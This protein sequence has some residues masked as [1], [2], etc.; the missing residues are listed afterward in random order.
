[1]KEPPCWRI[2]L[3]GGHSGEFCDHAEGTLREM[4]E[5]AVAAGY[6]TFGVSE[7]APRPEAFLYE[8]ERALGWDAEKL[9]ADFHRYTHTINTLA[10]AFAPQLM[11]LRGFEAEV[12]PQQTYV[13][14]MLA[15]RTRQLENGRPAFDYM[16]GSVHYVHEI[17][18]DGAPESYRT[19]VEACGGVT[20]FAKSYYAQVAEMVEALR[21]EVVG[22]LDLIRKNARAVGLSPE[23]LETPE[24]KAAAET[25]LEAIR[26][27]GA[28]LDLNT[29]GWRK[30]LD[31]PYPA[32]WLVQRAHA[33]GIPFC[34]GDDS[35]RPK[36]VGMGLEEARLYLLRNG[37]MHITTLERSE[38]GSLLRRRCPL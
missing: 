38:D 37:V 25:A 26:A 29:A 17:Q 22:H 5:A 19:A 23:A 14:T 31:T 6:R 1:M 30:G 4:L 3:H 34:F 7:H 24:I 10:E 32:P 8:E 20:S 33:M 11:V 16:V 12:V 18:I 21:P 27:Y 9:A 36:E 15:L 35:H 28:I 2:S 13:K